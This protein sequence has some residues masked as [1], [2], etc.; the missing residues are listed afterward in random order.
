M[1]KEKVLLLLNTFKVE[2][3]VAKQSRKHFALLKGG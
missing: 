2:V 1:A 3:L